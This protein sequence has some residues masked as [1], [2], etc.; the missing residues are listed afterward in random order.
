MGVTHGDE[1]AQLTLAGIFRINVKLHGEAGRDATGQPG[2]ASSHFTGVMS[3][4]NPE[5][6]GAEETQTLREVRVKN[7]NTELW[8]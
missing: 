5:L 6:E 2:A 3:R 8:G 7:L 1:H 4:Q